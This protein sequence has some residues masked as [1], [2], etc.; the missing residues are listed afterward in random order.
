MTI[1]R[2]PV[3]QS[4]KH[5]QDFEYFHSVSCWKQRPHFPHKSPLASHLLMGCSQAANFLVLS[6]LLATAPA[7]MIWAIEQAQDET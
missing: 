1:R 6:R 7:K 5:D 2:D 3:C 4:C